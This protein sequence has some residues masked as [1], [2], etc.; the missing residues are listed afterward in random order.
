[1]Y[2]YLAQALVRANYTVLTYDPRGQG[3]SDQIAA[4]G[5]L[6]S[7]LDARVFWEGQ[8]DA[9]DF[10]RSS[11][12]LPHPYTAICAGTYPTTVDPYNPQWAQVD[13]ERL[14]IAGHSLGAIGVAVVQGYGAPESDPWPGM[15]DTRN[16]V[17]AAVGLDSLINPDGTAFAPVDNEPAP[18]ELLGL[19]VQVGTQGTLPRFAPRIPSMNFSADYALASIVPY[20]APPD[21]ERHKQTLRTWQRAGVPFYSLTFQGTTHL[22]Y[23]PT[24]LIP[25]TS[26]CPAPNSEACQNGFGAPAI[27]YYTVAWFDRWLKVPGEVGYD[28]ADMRLIDDAGRDGA[29]K[30]SFRFRSAR[31]FPD[32]T[33]R[34]QH[35]EDSRSGCD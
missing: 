20:I 24:P 3:R 27:S 21:P 26:W 33:G 18:P 4:N 6:G 34:R 16:P 22:D 31:D 15:L 14:G 30:M 8:V 1:M 2:W 29:A 5:A 23:S 11:P 28:D 32:R 25:A 9:I 10:A 17:R 35:C 12:G 19:I 7:N 13:L